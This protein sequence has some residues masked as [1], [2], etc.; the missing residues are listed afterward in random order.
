M[1][2]FPIKSKLPGKAKFQIS[3]VAGKYGDASE[4]SI[5]VLPPAT[6]ESYS[7]WGEVSTEDYAYLQKIHKP[8]DALPQFGGIEVTRY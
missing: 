7:M 1:I 5:P 2:S 6:A 3:C 4:I 8:S